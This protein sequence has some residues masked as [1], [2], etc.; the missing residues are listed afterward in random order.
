MQ[1]ESVHRTLPKQRPGSAGTDKS[2]RDVFYR[3]PNRSIQRQRVLDYIQV[4]GGFDPGSLSGCRKASSGEYSQRKT[5][6]E[7]ANKSQ[8]ERTFEFSRF[9]R[10]SLLNIYHL[11][12]KL[13][14][15]DEEIEYDLEGVLST[16]KEK[17]L[18]ESMQAYGKSSK[19]S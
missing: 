12:H 7:L 10:L 16:D 5:L 14:L 8:S 17:E 18:H 6:F 3:D 19:T 4:G 11:Q 9:E 1:E 15:L 13:T 2:V